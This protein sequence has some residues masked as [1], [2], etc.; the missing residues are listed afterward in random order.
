MGKVTIIIENAP[1]ATATLEALAHEAMSWLQNEARERYG[2]EI[3]DIF[4]VPSDEE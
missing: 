3:P 2:V 1:I 4:V